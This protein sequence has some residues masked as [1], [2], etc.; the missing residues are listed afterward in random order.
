M[1]YN[2][3]KNNLNITIKKRKDIKHVKGGKNENIFLAII[4]LICIFTV[5]MAYHEDQRIRNLSD[6]DLERELKISRIQKNRNF[7]HNHH[8]HHRG[9]GY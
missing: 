8:V 6:H 7:N 2:L 4:I 9:F 3:K 1:S 5:F